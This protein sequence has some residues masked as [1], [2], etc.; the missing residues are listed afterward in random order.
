MTFGEKI[1]K[2]RKE[3]GLSQEELSVQLD[4]TRQAKVFSAVFTPSQKILATI[5]IFFTCS[6]HLA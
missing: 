4:V 5:S 6:I 2:L 3:H 1:Q